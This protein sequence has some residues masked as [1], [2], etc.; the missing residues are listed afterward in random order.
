MDSVDDM[1]G[2]GFQFI[3]MVFRLRIK[4]PHNL[5]GRV[6][7]NKELGWRI[8]H[9]LDRPTIQGMCSGPTRDPGHPRMA[10]CPWMAWQRRA[11]HGFPGWPG[12]P[13]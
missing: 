13:H 6:E 5:T 12:L 8:H 9:H 11:I 7:T 10:W 2:V 4:I 1:L 3:E